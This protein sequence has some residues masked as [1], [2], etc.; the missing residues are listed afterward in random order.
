MADLLYWNLRV[1]SLVLARVSLFA[2]FL[3]LCVWIIVVVWIIEWPAFG[4]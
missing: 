4:H 1:R 2:G 3:W